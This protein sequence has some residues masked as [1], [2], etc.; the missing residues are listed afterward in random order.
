LKVT[1]AIKAK[2]RIKSGGFYNTSKAQLI[3][4]IKESRIP[5]L[6]SG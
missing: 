4:A 5:N 2:I 3:V 6:K 1:F